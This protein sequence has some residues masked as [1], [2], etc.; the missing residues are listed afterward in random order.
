MEHQVN[1]YMMDYCE[2]GT[3]QSNN[4][5]PTTDNYKTIKLYSGVKS[6]MEAAK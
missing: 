3:Q 6:N 1:S 2:Y 5:V 4:R